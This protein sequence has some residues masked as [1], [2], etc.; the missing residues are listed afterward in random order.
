MVVGLC[1]A[2]LQGSLHHICPVGL[3]RQCGINVGQENYNPIRRVP[4]VVSGD[5]GSL[6]IDAIFEEEQVGAAGGVGGG[7]VVAGGGGVGVARVGAGARGP[8]GMN[9]QMM[10]LHSLSTQICREVHEMKLAQV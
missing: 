10:A 5:Q 4:V 1:G 3:E 9:A 6:F 7:A 8:A 2:V